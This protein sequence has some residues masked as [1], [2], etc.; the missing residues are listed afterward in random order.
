MPV[1]RELP[2]R[3]D[4]RD[5][6]RLID[7]QEVY[8]RLSTGVSPGRRDLPHLQPMTLT[9]PGEDHQIFVSGRH[10]EVLHPVLFLGAHP[11][12]PPPTPPLGP[13]GIDLGPLD[14]SLTRDGDDHLFV[15]DQVLDI[16]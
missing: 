4:G 14:V 10:E 3:N 2:H 1:I 6:V 8:D 9:R 11:L 16:E 7:V 12:E 15:R 13:V 5:V